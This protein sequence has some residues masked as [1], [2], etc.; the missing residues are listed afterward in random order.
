MIKDRKYDVV[1]I[2]VGII[3]SCMAYY[4]SRYKLK[5]LLLEKNPWIADETSH[6]NG[7]V[8]HGGFDASEKEESQLNIQGNNIWRN[9]LLTKLQI[10]H[11]KIHSIVLAFNKKEMEEV[12]KLFARGIK[13]KVLPEN[14]R[15]IKKDEL[16]KIEPHI[17][18]NVVGA[19]LCNSSF[20]IDPVSACRAM[21]SVAIKNNV[22]LE[23]NAEVTNIQQKKQNFQIEVNQEWKIETK[24]I[25]N[26]SGHYADEISRMANQKEFTLRA[27]R[28]EYRILSKTENHKVKNILYKIPTI[29]G[30][31]VTVSPLLDGRVLVGPT[32]EENIKKEDT[33]LV[34]REKFEE[35]G[36]I[37]TEIIPD[38]KIERTEKILSGSR[39]IYKETNDFLIE[40]SICP[41]FINIAGTQSPA[42]SSSPAISKK[43]IKMLKKAN[44]KLVKKEVFET[45][46]EIVF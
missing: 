35:I 16:M 1:I 34:T 15:I 27:R 33:R 11:K 30:K 42:L 18:K 7:G 12:K 36:K 41:N 25:I 19:L 21:V 29:H 43:V 5:I 24:F 9:E 8:I 28:G 2:G 40:N 31:G 14:L 37:G 38:L 44:L 6:G 13:N 22:S 23:K 26:A 39:P 17:S 32:A 45:K 4:L 3:G 46:C 20:L 10:P